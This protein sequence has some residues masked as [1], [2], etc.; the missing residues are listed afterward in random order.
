M[1]HLRAVK[2][3]ETESGT[4]IARGWRGRR[5]KGSPCLM[6]TEF[7]FCKMEKFWRWGRGDRCIACE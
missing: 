3:V 4:V 2:F 7:Q 5:R 1:R 6:G